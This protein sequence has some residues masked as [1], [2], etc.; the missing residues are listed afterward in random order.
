MAARQRSAKRA[1]RDQDSSSSASMCPRT[2]VASIGATPPLE[3]ATTSGERSTIAGRMKVERAPSSATLTGMPAARAATATAS[4]MAATSVAANTMRMP[5]TSEAAKFRRRQRSSPRSAAWM[6]AGPALGATTVTSAPAERSRAILRAA[7]R[8]P[9]TTSAG[10]CC[11]S[12]KIGRCLMASAARP[13]AD[14]VQAALA[15]QAEEAR[16]LGGVAGLGERARRMPVADRDVATLPQRVIRQAVA[17]QVVVHVAVGPVEDRMDLVARRADALDRLDGRARAR[18]LAPQ[19]GEPGADGKFR[20]RALHR[21][22][23]VDL[24]VA[25]DA[26]SAVFPEPAVARLDPGRRLHR[27]V[28]AQVEVEPLRQLV[29]EAVSLREE[30]AGVDQDDRCA[31]QRLCHEMQRHRGLRTE[32]G[33]EDARL[34]KEFARPLD[35]RTRRQCAQLCVQR[36][37]IRFG[38]Q[39]RQPER[40]AHHGAFPAT[41]ASS[42]LPLRCR[43]SPN[44]S[45]GVRPADHAASSGSSAARISGSS[46]FSR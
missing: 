24:V 44:A 8:P 22:D 37:D 25:L 32:G 36:R 9:P 35:T 39:A 1:S 34:R 30:I 27:A 13:G 15:L 5:A 10:A 19:P 17:L 42:S 11:K 14:Q 21:L 45:F 23:F 3:T 2:A 4:L 38:R 7:T 16:V 33:R 41:A 12:T 31:R 46:T 26:G 6:M 18:L 29:D 28:D 43:K 20:E 40:G